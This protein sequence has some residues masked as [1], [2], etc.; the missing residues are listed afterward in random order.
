M[1]THLTDFL[2]QLV[3]LSFIPFLVFLIKKKTLKGFFNWM[4]LKK[5][6]TRA[7]LM[8]L[9]VMVVAATP[10]ILLSVINQEFWE[11]MTNPKTVTGYFRAQ[12][13]STS[14]VISLLIVAVLK[15]SLTEEIFF[16]G[17]VAKR[18]ISVTGFRVGNTIQAI[19]FGAVHLL[20]FLTITSNVLFLC[21]M[22][23]FPTVTSYFKGYLNEKMADGSIIP[24]W[25]AHGSGNII[26]YSTIGFIL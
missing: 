11:I 18:L 16:R 6:N 24:G 2:F 9:L 22:L 7:N 14:T 13:F 15:T 25:I 5:S 8:A 19:I 21:V 17:F 10:L 3:A 12:G 20:I 26:A 23:I 4:G 1:I